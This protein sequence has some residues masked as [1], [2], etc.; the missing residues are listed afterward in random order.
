MGEGRI[1]HPGGPRRKTRRRAAVTVH[2]WVG[3]RVAA[4]FYV[5][6]DDPYRPE[7]I[8][9]MEF[10]DGLIV[11]SRL[12][13]PAGPQVSFAESL[14]ETMDAPL[15]GAPRR[16]EQVRVGDERL[17]AEIRAL[18]PDIDVVVA[19]TP[20]LH[21][22]LEEMSA[23]MPGDGETGPSYFEDGRISAA[24]VEALFR[25]AQALYLLAPWQ[26]ADD[27]QLLRLDIPTL[28]VEGA[29]LSIIG[30]LGESLGFIIFPSLVAYDRFLGAMGNMEEGRGPPDLGTPILS[31]NFDRGADL[32][33]TM[34]REAA[35]HGWPVA[36]AEAYPS[37][38]HRDRDGVLRPLTERDVRIVTACAVSLG[39]FF[40]KHGA[41]FEK[42]AFDP[43]CESFMDENNLE[44]RFTVPYEAGSMF[45][46]NNP[47]APQHAGAPAP[48]IGRNAPCPC[49]SGK[50]YKKCCMTGD[51]AVGRAARTPAVHQMDNR[52]VD[53]ILGFA[54]ER[55]GERWVQEVEH[56]G[57]A[58][59]LPDLIIPW[60]VYDLGVEGKTAA[61]WYREAFGNRLSKSEQAWLAAQEDAWLSMWEVV[62]VDPGGGVSL[63][64]QLTGEN[65]DVV[66]VKA[67]QSLTLRDVILARVVDYEEKSL[68]CGV[69]PR[70]L[71]PLAAGEALK[72]MRGW[73]RRK[74]RVPVERLR[75]PASAGKLMQCWD[76]AVE[77]RDRERGT[78][79]S[80]QNTD[81]DPLLL[82]SDRFE[83]DPGKGTEI[84]KRLA[85]LEGAE[86]P[87]AGEKDR[88]YMFTRRSKS[89]GRGGNTVIGQVVIRNG[90]V[91]AKTNSVERADALRA[92]V[93]EACGDLIRFRARDHSDPLVTLGA[94][95][96]YLGA[97]DPSDDIA[98]EDRVNIMREFKES[99]YAGWL[100]EPVPAL[101]GKTPRQATRT[102]SDRKRLELLLKEHENGEARLPQEERFD[103]SRLRAELGLTT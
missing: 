69:H 41:R 12:I 61:Q 98:D 55:F 99:Y 2:E 8:L 64:D 93:E 67:S 30:A 84:E 94:G 51:E 102:K 91:L 31:L 66:D 52:L 77:A 43:V 81:G 59:K 95:G 75:Q 88:C 80:L 53:E 11:G 58:E 71:P 47:V 97:G 36:S 85:A 60:A 7:M 46:A 82:T 6:D 96:A 90:A 33:P 16:P 62:G 25:A 1:K 21:K 49:G 13:D 87:E 19:P 26:G 5:T 39:A 35:G 32:A 4:P 45:E 68:L 54:V 89:S 70:P 56:V 17:A 20:E 42:D 103:F 86:P 14:Q 74:R 37:I 44:V 65:R 27:S 48:K 18:A 28:G 78:P 100:D 15:V 34:R 29:C 40:V 73:L 22:L 23:S 72:R 24:L 50:K 38:Q 76:D 92:R 57:D 9:W 3:G 10:P 83:F 101:A 79:P 63:E